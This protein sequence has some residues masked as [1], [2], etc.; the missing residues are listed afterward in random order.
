M[1]LE[2]HV[3]D[4]VLIEKRRPTAIAKSTMSCNRRP[5]CLE[6]GQWLGRLV[7]YRNSCP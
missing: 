6:T 7:G 2:R 1:G 5:G 4:A 3:L